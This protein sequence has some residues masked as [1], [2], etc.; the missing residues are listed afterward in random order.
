MKLFLKLFLL[1]I[2]FTGISNA[3]NIVPI[4][5]LKNNDGNG[6]PIDT[7]KVFKVT[8]IVTSSNQFG[9]NG[10]G[11]VQD[12]TGAISIFGSAFA[13]PVKIGD[14][15]IV[16]GTLT[17]FRGLTQFDANRAGF[18]LQ[19]ISSNKTVEPQVI[20]IAQ[21][22]SQQW[23]GFEEFESEL[24]RINNVQISG[25]GNFAGG[26]NYT[27]TDPTGSAEMRIDN[28]V[29][30]IIGTPIPS[31]KVDIIGILGQFKF[32]APFNSGYQIMPRF[33]LDIVDDGKPVILSPII[34]ANVDTSS[35]SVFFNTA[36]NGNSKVKYG[37]TTSLELDSVVVNDDTTSHRVDISG[38][39]PATQYYFKV[40]STNSVGTSESQL[41]SVS[42]SSADTTL[43][44]M[45]VYFNFS[46]DNS[47]ALPGNEAIGNVDLKTKL[48]ERINKAKY[49]IDL[50]LYSFFGMN[51][52]AD[53][54]IIARDRGV[55]VR[56]VYDS[57][58]TQNSMQQLI[59][60]GIK[61]SK[62]PSFLNGIM[63]N[64]FIIFDARDSV[65]FND[66]VWTGSWN[67]TSAEAT[68]KNSAIEINDPTIAKA[69]QTEFEE[70]WGS[71]TDTPN[72][73]LAKFGFQKSDNTPHSFII[74]KRPVQ[75]YFSP[76]DGTSAKIV[77]EINNADFS[78]YMALLVLTRDEIRDAIINA[79]GRGI[80]D[81][82]AVINDV[83]T[84]G[85]DFNT[86]KNV[87]PEFWENT[88]NVLHHKYGIVDASY[89]S[90]D[91]VVI[92]GS[93][94]W[95]S[96]AENNND[97]NTL[98]I[99]DKLIANQYL[100]EFKKRYNEAGGTATF[101]IPTGIDEKRITNFNYKLFQNYPNPFNPVTTIK[102]EVPYAQ[103]VQLKIYDLLGREVAT[104]VNDVI[105]AGVMAVDFNASNLA[106]GMYIYTIKA[107][108]FITS[109][110][111][112]LLK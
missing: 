81:V 37:K 87:F 53:A 40:F 75:L 29:T 4:S 112:I 63:H 73:S 85:S 22:N 35:F 83:S 3:Q 100:Q 18:S 91:P 98:I 77:N 15:V 59:N 8:G 49:S 42:T 105:P 101:F 74:G 58:T 1:L 26:T 45:N 106:S 39:Q 89:L 5:D 64:K 92:V 88:G 7:G 38:L 93:H 36:R 78:I 19:I 47:V 31:G 54:L 86:L 6:V 97:E 46:V 102:F 51:D 84:S 52:V 57:R 103:K 104:L 34:A 12:L 70:M 21:I 69:Y 13:N 11:S 16:S 66:W 25:S 108:K 24:I 23:N 32:A 9:N 44:E 67:V 111:L 2:V 60:A 41:K 72:S 68:W 61:I 33:I 76:S 71:S 56:V 28:D 95:S 107:D 27:I 62:R 50:A 55:K 65:D 110:K 90:N 80:T 94:N 79:S 17:H 96:S 82:R 99:H 48:L 30:T 10:P 109:K 43:G 20:T 14:S